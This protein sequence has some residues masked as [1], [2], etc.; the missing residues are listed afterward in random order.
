[1]SL[2]LWGGRNAILLPDE[3]Y[4]PGVTLNLWGGRNQPQSLQQGGKPGVTPN[5]WG[6]RN[7]RDCQRTMALPA[8][9]LH[10]RDTR[11]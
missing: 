9:P 4:T 7:L 3:I 6:G 8:V 2:N 10:L 5:L 1:M 11:E